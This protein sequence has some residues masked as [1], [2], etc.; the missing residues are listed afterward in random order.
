MIP[1]AANSLAPACRDVAEGE[2]GLNGERARREVI[3]RS[4]APKPARCSRPK[5]IL[6][7][8]CN[9]VPLSGFVQFASSP[10][11]PKK[12]P[13]RAFINGPQ[14]AFRIPA[15]APAAPEF[16]ATTCPAVLSRRSWPAKPEASER[17][18]AHSNGPAPKIS[19]TSLAKPSPDPISLTISSWN[20]VTSALPRRSKAKAGRHRER[21]L[22][23]PA[24]RWEPGLHRELALDLG[25]MLKSETGQR[26]KVGRVGT[27]QKPPMGTGVGQS[28]LRSG[29]HHGLSCAAYPSQ[30]FPNHPQPSQPHLKLRLGPSRL[31]PPSCPGVA[32]QRS[33]K[34]LLS[35]GGLVAP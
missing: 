13:S 25:E 35:E 34:L 24:L 28:G 11:L 29:P 32:G 10:P 17:R 3:Q 30:S 18:R 19:F 33:R 15:R 26:G 14:A 21:A 6:V 4:S 31:V 7:K 1:R 9:T 2:G 8:P 16:A 22:D 23:L 12:Y 20:T 5:N 27:P